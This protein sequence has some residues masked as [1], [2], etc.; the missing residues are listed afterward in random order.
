MG[1]S[2]KAVSIMEDIVAL[3]KRNKNTSHLSYAMH[4]L[5]L[6]HLWLGEF[7]KSLEYLMKA[8]DLAKESGEYQSMGNATVGLGELFIEREDFAEAEKYLNESSSIWEEAGDTDG[9]VLDLFPVLSR[10]YLRKGEFEKAREIIEKTSEHA[11]KA[12]KRLL[13]PYTEML[14]GMLFREQKNWQKSV[15]QFEKSL[16]GYKSLNAQKWHVY[17]FAELLYEYG[18][19]HLDRNQEGDREKARSLLNQALETFQKMGAKKDVEKVEARLLY[20]ETGK[21]ASA[22]PKPIDLVA[23]GYADLDKLLC[24]GVRSSSAVA[25]ISPSS[26]ERDSLIKSFLKTG[27]VRGEVT[28]YLTTSVRKAKALAEEFQSNF[29]LFVCNPRADAIAESSPNVIKLNGVENLTEISIALTSAI[30]RLDASL[31]GPRR[32]CVEIVSDALLQHHAVQTRK[33]LTAL[34]TELMSTGFTV[35]AV[36]DPQM[37]PPEELHAILGLFDGEINIYEKGVERFLRIK[38]MSD[39]KYLEDE[40]LLGKEDLQ[41]R[42]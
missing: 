9:Q 14:K 18:L 13:I 7:D 6:V 24:G 20:I 35:L 3:D 4:G 40:L 37:H 8:R 32:A 39:Q 34:T 30:H 27:A 41:K 28:F 29:Y 25:L 12:K 16:S 11:A 10:L 33:W 26:N 5:G 38:R 1:E 17:Q 23:T 31:K 15:E 22:V 21:A 19:M 2:H 36:V 42:M